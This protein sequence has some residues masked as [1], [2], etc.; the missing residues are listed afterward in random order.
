MKEFI[1]RTKEGI[2]VNVTNIT[3]E[4]EKRELI[5]Q[6]LNFSIKDTDLKFHQQE[7]DGIAVFHVKT[8]YGYDS[9]AIY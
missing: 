1:N 2:T 9:V 8:E 6:L 3:T 5:K 7:S 4:K